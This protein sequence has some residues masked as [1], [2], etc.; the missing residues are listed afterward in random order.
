MT[1]HCRVADSA[2]KRCCLWCPGVGASEFLSLTSA[3]RIDE[4]QRGWTRPLPAINAGDS[5]RR[6]NGSA[7]G[8]AR[9]L[10]AR[11]QHAAQVI[12][13]PPVSAPLAA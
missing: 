12:L 5:A 6:R 11:A 8:A 13:G 7:V 10:V 1:G 9:T 4:G 3:G 2:V